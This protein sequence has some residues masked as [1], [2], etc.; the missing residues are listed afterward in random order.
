[1]VSQLELN[2]PEKYYLGIYEDS[3]KWGGYS[4]PVTILEVADD[5]IKLRLEQ[6]YASLAKVGAKIELRQTEFQK[7]LGMTLP[8]AL[9]DQSNWVSSLW[10]LEGQFVGYGILGTKEKLR[11]K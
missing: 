6:D 5:M 11:R 3:L 2:L 7:A 1:M 10:D 4:V 8:K 9:K